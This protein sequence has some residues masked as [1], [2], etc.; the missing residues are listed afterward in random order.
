MTDIG[1]IFDFNGTMFFD[2]SKHEKAWKMYI[3]ELCGIS[4]DVSEFRKY[5]HGRTSKDI[6]KHFLKSDYELSENMVAQLSEEKE[7]IYRVLCQEDRDNL[8]L[9]PG[10]IAFL[11]YLKEANVPMTIATAANWDN[12]DFYFDI[13]E[14]YKWFDIDNVIYDNGTLCGK[15]APDYYIA[16]AKKIN[17]PTRKCLVFED[18]E[19]GILSAIN[20]GV[21]NVVVVTGDS[22]IDATNIKQVIAIVEDYTMLNNDLI[23]FI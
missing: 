19:A 21:E 2:S 17:I 11:D 7:L 1:V 12:V 8:K 5:I 20:A 23:I 16:A 13:F 22:H 14:L 4:I 3:E 6:L 18:G 15:P 10:L 9:A